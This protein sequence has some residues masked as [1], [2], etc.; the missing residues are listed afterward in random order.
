MAAALGS[1]SLGR[2]HTSRRAKRS[3]ASEGIFVGGVKSRLGPASLYAH[4]AD[5][6]RAAKMA[7]SGDKSFTPARFYLVCHA[8]E[9]GLRAYLSLGTRSLEDLPRRAATGHDLGRLL[10]K[11]QSL[12]LSHLIRFRAREASEIRK[13]SL[14]YARQVFEYP[15]LAEALRGYPKKPRFQVLLAAA[16]SL[17]SAIRDVCLAGG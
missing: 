14:Y 17:I 2:P 13:A 5:Y 15:A 6:L 12:S 7:G 8:L 16:E 4:A 3:A 9:L 1:D 10:S 11:A